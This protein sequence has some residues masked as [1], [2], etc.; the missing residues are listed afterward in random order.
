MVQ[1]DGQ[2]IP[3][4]DFV[5]I[6]TQFLIHKH[7]QH[8]PFRLLQVEHNTHGDVKTTS[9]KRYYVMLLLEITMFVVSTQTYTVIDK[10]TDM[11]END[12]QQIHCFDF[13]Q[14]EHRLLLQDGMI[15]Q[16]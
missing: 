1:H 6:E 14:I 10:K 4:H 7:N 12:F 11:H 3:A 9:K 5:P 13:V 2:T 8:H 16:H 15:L